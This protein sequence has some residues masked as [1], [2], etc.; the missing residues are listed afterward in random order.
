MSRLVRAACA[1][2]ALMALVTGC[3]GGSKSTADTVPPSAPPGEYTP[4]AEIS[5]NLALALGPE[6]V[7]SE[8]IEE[9]RDKLPR[10]LVG[11]RA[12]AVYSDQRLTGLGKI[13]DNC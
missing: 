13:F 10:E 4:S 12:N 3:G 2:L 5:Q 11:D 7:A 9:K 8:S 1:L 6:S